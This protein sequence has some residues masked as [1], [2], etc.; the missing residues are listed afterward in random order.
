VPF[1]CILP[2]TSFFVIVATTC[3]KNHCRVSSCCVRLYLQSP[4][5]TILS[6]NFL[7]TVVHHGCVV[8]CY[9]CHMLCLALYILCYLFSSLVSSLR[10][11]VCQPHFDYQHIYIDLLYIYICV[12]RT[13]CSYRLVCVVDSL[14]DCRLRFCSSCLF[15]RS[16]LLY[17]SLVYIS[18]CVFL[19][20]CL[21]FL[22]FASCVQTCDLTSLYQYF[23]CTIFTLWFCN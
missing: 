2:R 12:P 10:M 8:W 3:S 11:Q 17:S 21:H 6:L 1:T 20:S 5:P 7:C 18:I 16:I 19:F 15:V 14:S 13:Y 4:S 22:T 9:L 23:P